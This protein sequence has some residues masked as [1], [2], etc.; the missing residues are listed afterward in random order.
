MGDGAE[1]DP[2]GSFD[3][4]TAITD[5]DVEGLLV[6]RELSWSGGNARPGSFE[7]VSRLEQLGAQHGRIVSSLASP[8]RKYLAIG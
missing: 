2:A 3:N 6:R 1:S 8:S 7:K 4:E 5:G